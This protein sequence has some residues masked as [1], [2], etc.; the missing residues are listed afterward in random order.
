VP[1]PRSGRDP[2]DGA[3][4]ETPADSSDPAAAVG[5]T[6][7]APSSADPVGPGDPWDAAG[8]A[9][10]VRHEGGSPALVRWTQRIEDRAPRA[11][12]VVGFWLSVYARFARHRG[13]VLAG[14]LAFFALLS[15]VP[16]ALSL[17]VVVAVFIDPAEFVKDVQDALAQTPELLQGLAPFLDQIAGLDKTS[18]RSLGI[19]GLVGFLLSLYAA[20]R[21]VY[22]GRQ[23]LDI[24]FE[25]EPQHP[26]VLGR[27]VALV[28]T[29][30]TQVVIIAAVITLG[31]LPRVLDTLGLAES[32][33]QGLRAIRLPAA[34]V[35]IYLL[36]TAAMRFGIRARRAVPWLNPGAAL[37]TGLIVLG[38]F[39]LGWYVSVSATYS[40]IVTVLGGVIAL[41][42]WLYVIGLAIVGSAEIEGMLLGFRRRDVAHP[43]GGAGP[44]ADDRR[45]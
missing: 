14:G 5:R 45:P 32:A 34:L 29:L 19:A 4:P 8:P 30:V 28:V 18:L 37:G 27:A 1:G 42:I 17:G 43:P 11:G 35:V 10:R 24:A 21:F 23:V 12:G 22:V 25:L 6:S 41:E 2:S 16:A 38:T 44:P 20:S 26:S 31:L 15:L 39:G 3:E 40:Q 9:D 7:E 36:L 33:S 13:T